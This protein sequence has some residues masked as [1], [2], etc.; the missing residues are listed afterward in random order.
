VISQTPVLL[1]L[2]G[3][4]ERRAR[5][6][7]HASHGIE[8]DTPWH[9]HDRHQVLYA[10]QGALEVEGRDG[11][12][13]VPHLHGVFISAGV[14][15]RTRLQRIASGSIFLSADMVPDPPR[16][17]RV[18]AAAPLMREMMGHAMRWPIERPADPDGDLFFECFASLCHGWLE[19]AVELRLPSSA[20]PR[21]ARAVEY[22]EAE[23]ASADFAGACR[24]A[25]MSA[26]S[27]R[28]HF[29]AATGI[30]WEEYL[31]RLRITHALEHLE[32]GNLTIGSIADEI[33]YRSQSAL[34]AAF[35]SLVGCSPSEYR[36]SWRH[37]GV[38]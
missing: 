24:A 18:F 13:R 3:D 32:R 35:R 23:L 25:A 5:A 1:S 28:R 22:A 2:M 31:R 33:G 14:E 7:A 8:V 26:R 16:A 27:L 4:P 34:A 11:R 15:H 30:T 10:F 17:L 21:I 20:D 37:K 6:G 12:Y 38:T 29:I 36:R 19:A 9:K